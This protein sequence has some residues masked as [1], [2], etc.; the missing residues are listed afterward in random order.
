VTSPT[1]A[2]II[3]Y[4]LEHSMSP[5][6]HNA[7]FK[8][9][10]LDIRYEAWPIPPEELPATIERV[11]GDEVLGLSVTV[12]YKQAVMPLLDEIDPAADAIGSVNTLVKRGRSLIGHNTDKQ[13]FI[14]SLRE[15]GCEPGGLR[16]LVLG[17]GG[18]E[19]AVAYGLV[20]AG[21]ASITLAGRNPERV[22]AA[23]GQLEATKPRPVQV[24]R[25]SF[26]EVALTRAAADAD[27]IVNTT[28]I[29]MRHSPHEHESPLPL[30]VLRPGLWVVDIV[31]NPLETVLLHEARNAGA[32]A[33][34]G[35]GMLVYQ[36]VAQQMLWTGK[37]PPSDIMREA[38]L[39]A[40]AARE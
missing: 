23:A 3:G 28:P 20:E 30:A 40:M 31:Y 24:E 22:E 32:H 15:A 5:A 8:A 37:E 14:R 19:R 18:A 6:M 4:P 9:L 7:A 29:G 13:G 17:V 27:L 33:V 34:D 16:A 21:V 10:G 38:A 1:V 11:R 35:L 26:D 12:P 36:G 2:A 39:A 25:L